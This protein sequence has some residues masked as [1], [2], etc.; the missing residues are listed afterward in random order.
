MTGLTFQ[1]NGFIFKSLTFDKKRMVLIMNKFDLKDNFIK[2][3]ELRMGE[4]P[5]SIKRKLNPLV[6]S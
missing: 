6:K 1:E 5:K 4:I 3:V 2:K